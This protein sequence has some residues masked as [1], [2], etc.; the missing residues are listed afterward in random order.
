M[1]TPQDTS[2]PADTT[3]ITTDTPVT[4]LPEQTVTSGP[5][6]PQVDDLIINE[7]TNDDIVANLPTTKNEFGTEQVIIN[8]DGTIQGL[9]TADQPSSTTTEK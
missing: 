6:N 8:A 7:Q 5:T 1:A 9:A 4:D 2:T 3:P